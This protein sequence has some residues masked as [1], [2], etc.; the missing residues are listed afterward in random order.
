MEKNLLMDTNMEHIYVFKLISI[1]THKKVK[2]EKFTLVTKSKL[3]QY[4]VQTNWKW[5]KTTGTN[6]LV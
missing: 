3:T 1:V 2:C 5:T 4:T 6:N